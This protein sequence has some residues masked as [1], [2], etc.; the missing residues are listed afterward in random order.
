[1]FISV[2]GQCTWFGGLEFPIPIWVSK[3]Q[4]KILSNFWDQF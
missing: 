2:V 3:H 4:M 1:M